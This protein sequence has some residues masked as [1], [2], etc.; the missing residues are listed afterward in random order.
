MREPFDPIFRFL[1]RRLSLAT[2]S[3]LECFKRR[4]AIR[5]RWRKLKIRSGKVSFNIRNVTF[6]PY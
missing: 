5:D 2:K 4:E 6:S 3:A 1:K